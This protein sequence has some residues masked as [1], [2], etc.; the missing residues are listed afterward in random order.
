M[1]VETALFFETTEQI[2]E[3]VFRSLRPHMPIPSIAVHF[4]E[5]A[6]A[7]CRIRLSANALR[8]D[9]SDL[10]QQA[11]APIQEALAGILVS[12][13]FKRKPSSDWLARYRRYMNRGDMRRRLADM[14][15]QRGR[16]IYRDPTGKVYDL[17]SLFEELNQE[18]FD[19]LMARPQLGWSLRCSTTTL[20][21]YDP[22]HHVIVLS[23]ALDHKDAPEAAVRY[24]LFHEMLHLRYPTV[25]RGA[26]R[27][28]HTKDFKTAERSYP[29]YAAGKK[30]LIEY[31]GRIR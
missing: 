25:H 14:K 4:R 16:K 17:C 19:G 15:R 6:N 28:V 12:K 9:I 7:N 2:Y 20:G 31:L 21:H 22:S 1:D 10:L 23:S 24:V 11:P 29:G 26:R 8:V 27:C 3:R 18:F 13:L 30:Q 5:Y